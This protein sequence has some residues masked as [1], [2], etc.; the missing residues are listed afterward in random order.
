MIWSFVL[1]LIFAI[2]FTS[3]VDYT[4][5][6]GLALSLEQYNSQRGISDKH[7]CVLASAIRN[8]YKLREDTDHF[9]TWE[10]IAKIDCRRALEQQ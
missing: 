9:A 6:D 10:M 3:S 2:F 1:T 7:D 8:E 4:P 5:K